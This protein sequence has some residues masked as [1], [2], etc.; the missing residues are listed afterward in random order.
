[1]RVAIIGDIETTVHEDGQDPGGA[2]AIAICLALRGVQVTLRSAVGRD[3]RGAT[4]LAILEEHGISTALVDRNDRVDT[5]TTYWSAEERLTYR[6]PGASIDKHARM[7]IYDLF[8]H[9]VLILDA[10]DQPLR[11]FLTDLPAHTAPA[12]RMLGTLRHLDWRKPTADEL[13]IAMRLDTV[14]GT[15]AQ[16]ATLTGDEAPLDRTREA[17]P[18]THLRAAVAI[19]PDAVQAID[20]ERQVRV[21]MA[22]AERY[23]P[24][25][26]AASAL[27]MGRHAPIPDFASDGIRA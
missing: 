12:V 14:I 13:A 17:M 22:N 24:D 27:L 2:A 16:L 15:A 26:V 5:A 11:R 23:F 8:G 25:I 4:T 20:R 6:L 21:E 1:M 7:D 18:G 19:L 3:E 9:D 10:A